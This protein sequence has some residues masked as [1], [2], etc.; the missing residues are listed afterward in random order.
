[1]PVHYTFNPF[2]S[3][4]CF[5]VSVVIQQTHIAKLCTEKSQANHRVHEDLM[6]TN[7]SVNTFLHECRPAV[8][9]AS[10]CGHY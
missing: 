1:M 2:S 4:V 10:R 6:Q 8:E 9:P 7:K 3:N 5:K